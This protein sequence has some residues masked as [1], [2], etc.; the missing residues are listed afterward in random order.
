MLALK[1]L[2]EKEGLTFN[3]SYERQ[4]FF[5]R[6]SQDNVNRWLAQLGP[7]EDAPRSEV[8]KK[9]GWD[10]TG[11]INLLFENAG[12][13]RD[14]DVVNNVQYADTMDSHRLAWYAQSV[15]LQK[16][17]LMWKALSR[18][19][20]QGKDS[21]IRP[22]RL[23]S[24]PMLL[25]CAAEVGLDLEES[26]RVLDSNVYRKE[27]LE[28]VEKM[29]AAGINSIPVLCFE[30]QGVAEGSWLENP[31]SRGRIIHH[32]SGNTTDFRCIFQQLHSVCLANM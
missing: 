9:M 17:E 28:I 30:V 21:E 23:D 7:P 26:K 5:L 8:M 27:I 1:E 13:D 25:E 4:P 14:M 12:I 24:R 31:K 10:K 11:G 22:I 19:Y 15:D 18:R 2:Q 16:G 29:H 20:F 3:L 6:G 32:G